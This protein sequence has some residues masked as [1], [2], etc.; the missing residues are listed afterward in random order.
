MNK[1]LLS[2]MSHA[3]KLTVAS[4]KTDG[5]QISKMTA[6]TFFDGRQFSKLTAIKFEN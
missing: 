3:R 5:R 6:V 2:S 1:G 4:F